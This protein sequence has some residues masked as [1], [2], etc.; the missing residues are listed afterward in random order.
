MEKKI[1]AG[2]RVTTVLCSRVVPHGKNIKGVS[3][4]TK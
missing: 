2:S 1:K 4:V 3:L